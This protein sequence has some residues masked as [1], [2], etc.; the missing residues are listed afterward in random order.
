MNAVKSANNGKGKA[1]QSQKV[2]YLAAKVNPKRRFHA[3]YDKVHRRDIPWKA[4]K[5]VK[6]YGG[7]GGMDA[8][9]MERPRGHLAHSA[10]RKERGLQDSY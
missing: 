2:L 4:W 10:G 3:L 7:S 5:R 9:Q 1:Q 6:V 8:G